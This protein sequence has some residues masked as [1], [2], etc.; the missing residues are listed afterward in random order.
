[1]ARY[2]KLPFL[3][4]SMFLFL[5]YPCKVSSKRLHIFLGGRKYSGDMGELKSI[6]QWPKIETSLLKCYLAQF[7][8][9]F[10]GIK[11]IFT[12]MGTD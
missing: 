3:F 4:P 1:M 2:C 8:V 7:L 6:K 10:I 11:G 5:I 9:I 12:F